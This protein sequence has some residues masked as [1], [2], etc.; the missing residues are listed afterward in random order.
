MRRHCAQCRVDPQTR[1]TTK[2]PMATTLDSEVG[3]MLSTPALLVNSLAALDRIHRSNQNTPDRPYSDTFR[4]ALDEQINFHVGELC[5]LRYTRNLGAPISL[6]QAELLS[7]LFLYLVD[8][9]LRGGNTRFVPGTFSFLRVCRRWNQVAVGFPR[10]WS[11]WVAGAVKSWPLFSSRSKNAPLSLTWRPQLLESARDALMDPAIPKRTHQLDFSGTR[12][13]LEF[14]LTI[15][16]STLP[17]NVSSIRLQIIEYDGRKPRGHFAR[18]LSSPFPKLS[19]LNIGNFL[20]SPSSPIFTSSNLASLKLFLPYKK[21]GQYTLVQFSQILQRHPNLRELD[22]SH[23]AI[24]LSG[25]PGTP[26]PFVLPQ[27]IDLRLYGTS[28]PILEF[29]DFIGMSSPLYN[30]AIHFDRTPDLR[31]PALTSALEKIIAAY[32]DYQGLHYPRGIDTLTI[33]APRSLLHLA[34]DA[35]SRSPRTS[36]FQL[37]FPWIGGFGSKEVL[38]VTFNLLPSGGVQELAV[39][40]M[41]PLTGEML[42]KMKEL[43]HLRLFN[44]GNQ[45]I[46]QTLSAL[47]ARGPGTSTKPARKIS[48]FTHTYK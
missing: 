6:L 3:G 35:R 31:L 44:Q 5:R 48:N 40:G 38:E 47:S 9:G 13:Q 23:G 25:T 26:V 17:S 39:D 11:L 27:L 41:L 42:K 15:F 12:G 20:P 32:Y 37:Q 8:F 30:V 14:F 10:L 43:L 29:V 45:D 16:R 7:E 2:N 4:T 22:L 34:F 24:P 19:K 1:S 18:L 36:N 46:G 28:E 33:A 21:K